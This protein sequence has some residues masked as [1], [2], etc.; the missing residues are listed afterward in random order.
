MAHYHPRRVAILL[1]LVLAFILVGCNEPKNQTTTPRQL[2][3]ANEIILKKGEYDRASW[4][5]WTLSGQCSTREQQLKKYGTEIKTDKKCAI[6]SGK[7]TSLYDNFRVQ[8]ASQMQIDH[9]VPLKEAEE[10]GARGWDSKRKNK[11]Y[12]DSENLIAVSGTSNQSKSDKDPAEWLPSNKAYI[13]EYV[14]DYVEVK[15]AYDLSFDPAEAKV[16][17]NI[18]KDC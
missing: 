7:W 14:D 9:I 2:K 18:L 5:K 15:E 11:F 12:N 16:I 13:C 6:V 3:V 10:S 8:S 4:G 17:Q 1:S